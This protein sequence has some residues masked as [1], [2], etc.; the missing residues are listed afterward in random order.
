MTVS[1]KV[2]ELAKRRGFFFVSSEIYGG[3]AG[4][5]DYGPYGTL[6]K[7]K[8]ENLWRKCF[9][10][11][12]DNFFEIETTNIMPEKVFEASGH[13]TNFVD[14]VAKCLKCGAFHRADH[15]IEE[16]LHEDFEGKSS[17][18]LTQLIKKHNI[19]WYKFVKKNNKRS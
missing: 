8:L 11:V 2:V 15:I 5:Y 17:K 14:P 6:M 18:D 1:E 13:L 19:K 10:S 4:F 7:R 9:L 3:M 16:F 12:D